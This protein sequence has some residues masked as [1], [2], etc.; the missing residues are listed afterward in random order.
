MRKFPPLTEGHP[1]IGE[2]CHL[3]KHPIKIGDATTLI[4]TKPASP[5]DEA[6]MLAGRAYT[7]EAALVHWACNEVGDL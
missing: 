7:A 1:A 2:I 6:K 4:S 5:D 3:C